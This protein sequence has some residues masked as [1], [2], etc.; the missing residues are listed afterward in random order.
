[1]L[2]TGRRLLLACAVAT[3]AAA[4]MPAAHAQ[5]YPRQ[6][7]RLIVPFAPGGA[8]PFFP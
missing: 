6:P 8:T 2:E 7:I 1:M 3:A 4:L 5:G